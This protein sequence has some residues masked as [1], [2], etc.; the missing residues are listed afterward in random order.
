MAGNPTLPTENID[1]VI[2]GLL[3]LEPNEID[4][5]DYETYKSYLKELLVKVTA[6]KRKIGSEEFDL[7]KNEFK[8]VR[9]KKGRFRLRPKKTKISASG[10]GLGGI[11]KQIKKFKFFKTK[12]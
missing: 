1:E 10:L 2:L 12:Q 7:V 8:R 4:E 11:G 3:S 6:S 9:G 5:L